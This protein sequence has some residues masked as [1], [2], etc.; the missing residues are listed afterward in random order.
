MLNAKGST[1][2]LSIHVSRVPFLNYGTVHDRCCGASLVRFKR[3]TVA[4]P[5][6]ESEFDSTKSLCPHCE[7]LWSFED[8]DDS[9]TLDAETMKN[10]AKFYDKGSFIYKIVCLHIHTQY[11]VRE[12]VMI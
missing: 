11:S 5:C 3:H 12:A 1:R 9:F 10:A 6:F 7:E 2:S 8:E 4:I